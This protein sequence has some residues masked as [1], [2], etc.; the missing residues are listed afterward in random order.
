MFDFFKRKPKSKLLWQ[1]S[2]PNHYV[3]RA[4]FLDGGLI[5]GEHRAAK[6]RQVS[7]FLLDDATG[8]P[9]WLDF[10]LTDS[11]SRKPV[12]E[13]WWVGIETVHK[14]LF[15]LHG[16]YSPSTP[17]HLG[18]WAFD[19]KTKSRQW[20][21]QDVGFLCMVDDEILVYR[22]LLVEGFTERAFLVLDAMTGKETRAFSE[23]G[24]LA[25]QMRV[26][27]AS[28][29]T[30]QGVSLPEKVSTSSNRFMEIQAKTKQAFSPANLVE[31]LDVIVQDGKIIL[32]AHEK[33]A[34]MVKN[35]SGQELPALDYTLRVF[36]ETGV[37]MFEDKLGKSMSGLLAD[38][39]F[40]RRNKL[41]FVKERETLCAVDL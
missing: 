41:Y 18:I 8:N 28:L 4:M 17:E 21:R 30:M 24:V 25:N 40:T 16:Y 9:L 29:E 2:N 26:A 35:Q 27:S 23:D 36:D 37:V 13:G 39:F 1:F 31:G 5:V 6:A 7:F 38:G 34:A 19:A 33:T 15:Y 14:N 22:N 10:M 12:G 11:A 32:G 20:E 3:W